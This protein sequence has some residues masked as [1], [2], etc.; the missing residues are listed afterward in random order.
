M[1]PTKVPEKWWKDAKLKIPGASPF[2]TRSGNVC[3]DS[4][5]LPVL[6]NNGLQEFRSMALEARYFRNFA[7]ISE[8]VR[9]NSPTVLHYYGRP[10][11]AIWLRTV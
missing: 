5:K 8:A 2:A 9:L 10:C 6:A 4:A 11:N 7:D 3:G 1:A